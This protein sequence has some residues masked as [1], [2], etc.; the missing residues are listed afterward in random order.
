[1]AH[2]YRA[3]G[4][5]V[6]SAVELPLPLAH[7]AG[8]GPNLSLHVAP[9]GAVPNDPAP[10]SRLAEYHRDGL[11]VYTFG[12]TDERIVLRYPGLCELVGDPAMADVTARLHPGVDPNLLAV[13]AAGNLLAVHLILRHQ[14][15]LHASA[16]LGDDGVVA[17][18]GASGM[19]KSALAAAYCNSGAALV[20]DDVMRTEICSDGQILVYPGATE[21]RLRVTASAL[22]ES[23]RAHAVRRTADGRLALRST[24]LATGPLTLRACVIPW[25]T[26]DSSRASV[27]RLTSSNALRELIRF[28]K[29]VGWSDTESTANTFQQLGNLV[30]RVPVFEARL[31]WGLPFSADV[32]DGLMAEVRAESSVPF[33][34]SPYLVGDRDAQR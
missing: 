23:A 7:S 30:E 6:S 8:Q 2:R 25:M 29:I 20:T 4:L 33:R 17:F 15:V 34:P 27:R 32:L 22:I 28:P 5:L 18:V 26:S 31:P 21:N 16:I 1:M 19:G 14:L 11:L 10:G 13:L 3:H 9:E 12:R 24:R